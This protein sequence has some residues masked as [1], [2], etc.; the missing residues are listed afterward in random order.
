MNCTHRWIVESP[1]D[2]RRRWEATGAEHTY[3]SVCKFCLMEREFVDNDSDE[4]EDEEYVDFLND[5]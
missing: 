5:K 3:K 4:D 2:A 1:W